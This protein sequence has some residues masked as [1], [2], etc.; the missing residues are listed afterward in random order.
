MSNSKRNTYGQ[1]SVRK[2]GKSWQGRFWF[3]GERVQVNIGKIAHL[4]ENQAIRKLRTI[5]E[6][7]EPAGPE[8]AITFGALAD[9]FALMKEGRNL[10]ANSLAAMG[11]AIRV[12]LKPEFEKRRADSLTAEDLERF[13]TKKLKGGAAPKSVENIMS[14]LSSI[15]DYGVK[16]KILKTNPA[17]DIEKVRAPKR[18]NF[19][20][21]SSD[22]LREIRAAFPD[23]PLGKQDSIMVLVAARS[24]LRQGEIISLRWRDIDWDRGWIR[25]NSSYERISK[26]HKAPKSHKSRALPLA[27]EVKAALMDH[28][29]TT[30]WNQDHDLVFPH[31]LTGHVLDGAS[32]NERFKAAV[33]AAGVRSAEYE[34]RTYRRKGKTTERLTTAICWHDLRH[35]FGTFMAASGVPLAALESWCGWADRE[36]LRIYVHYAP[37]GFELD[38]INKAIEADKLKALEFGPKMTPNQRDDEGHRGISGEGNSAL[39]SQTSPIG[40]K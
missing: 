37:A 8:A 23:T 27:D 31:P 21:L 22:E 11:S 20:V 32:L 38:L 24:G 17:R 12:H 15:L 5:I 26:Q 14:I 4:T 40:E 35:A 33:V 10:T 39:G 36:T 29:K 19:V 3:E 7:Y 13:Q 6:S 16:R 2:R 1:G 34:K 28:F 30:K 18:R 25:V 9:K